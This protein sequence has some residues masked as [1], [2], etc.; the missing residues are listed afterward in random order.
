MGSSSLETEID[1]GEKS[2]SEDSLCGI[3]RKGVLTF[4]GRLKES[5]V[6]GEVE[7]IREGLDA[8][9][10]NRGEEEREGGEELERERGV[11]NKVLALIVFIRRKD[12]INT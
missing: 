5:E 10:E 9:G 2:E 1:E 4:G 6:R 12:S 7:G 8:V 11:E 3:R